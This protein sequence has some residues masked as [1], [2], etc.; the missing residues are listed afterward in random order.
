MYSV[1][2]RLFS[3]FRRKPR[4]AAPKRR[5]QPI[6]AVILIVTGWLF[7]LAGVAGLVLP[8][9]P[10]TI[11]LVGGVMLLSRHYAWARRLLAAGRRRYPQIWRAIHNHRATL[12]R[13]W[14][15]LRGR[16]RPKRQTEPNHI[17][18]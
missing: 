5:N 6:K 18:R 17:T 12:K 8:V 4:S 9:V 11:L 3:G 14:M 15:R 16:F 7:I 2:S 13:F 10:G 1:F